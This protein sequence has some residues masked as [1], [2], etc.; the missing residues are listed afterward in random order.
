[1]TTALGVGPVRPDTLPARAEWLDSAH[2]VP[3]ARS[4]V[5]A[6][7]ALDVAAATAPEDLF[8]VLLSGGAS[9]LMALPADG[10]TLQDK[11]ETVRRLLKS[12]A[13]ITELNTVR[14][15]LSAIKG[16][17]LAAATEAPVVTLAISDVVGDDRSVIG[18]GPDCAG[19]EHVRRRAG[20]AR[21]AR[22]ACGVLC[23]RGQHPRTRA[24]RRDAGN[25]EA[26]RP[27]DDTVEC[28]HHRWTHHSR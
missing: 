13:T 3:D 14:K 9:A 23:R 10:I 2:P 27:A 26:R 18:S 21:R 22:R 17:R 7:R 19:P 8:I 1:M 15:H 25:T 5:A 28:A 11:Q 4:V 24:A 12:G 20:S 16:G 6:R